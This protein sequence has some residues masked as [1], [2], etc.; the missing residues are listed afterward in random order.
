[1]VNSLLIIS[2]MLYGWGHAHTQTIFERDVVSEFPLLELPIDSVQ[3][4]TPIGT[5]DKVVYNR[6]LNNT[7]DKK[8]IYIKNG[9]KEYETDYYGLISIHPSY[10]A[11]YDEKDNP[12]PDLKFYDR[13]YPIGRVNLQPDNYSLIVK[14]FSLL[15][16]YYDIHNFTKEGKLMSVVPLYYFEN[17][18]GMEERVGV[19]HIRSRI[20][21]DAKIHWWE[22]Y[23]RRTR[24]R[25]Y[26]LNNEGFLRF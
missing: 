26:V 6:Y 20:T 12:L 15:S 11:Q 1:M 23:P 25:V 22:Y 18:K 17:A 13:A 10:V 16:T 2:A 24:E 3:K 9:K 8:P 14:V 21:K 7:I 5:L 19:L 4:I